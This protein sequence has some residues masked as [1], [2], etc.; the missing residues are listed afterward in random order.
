ML[1]QNEMAFI[2]LL[3]IKPAPLINTRTPA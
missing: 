3:E 2:T 1:K